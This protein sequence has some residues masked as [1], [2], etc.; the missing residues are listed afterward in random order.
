MLITLTPNQKNTTPKVIEA[1]ESRKI[2]NDSKAMRFNLW[3]NKQNS[4]LGVYLFYL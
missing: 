4:N 2:Y 1:L 3:L